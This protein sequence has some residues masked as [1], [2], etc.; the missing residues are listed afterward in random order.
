LQPLQR[1]SAADTQTGAIGDVEIAREDG[2]IFEDIE[3]KHNIQINDMLI[4]DAEMLTQLK[5]VR[6]KTECQ[7]IVNGIISSLQ[8]YLRLLTEPKMII[9][10]YTDL[11]VTE[12][13]IDNE[14]RI[15]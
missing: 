6:A 8:Y 11:L 14:H 13:A 3:V 10:I 12:Q 5:E 1:H 7:I 4:R 2:S 9:P 15:A